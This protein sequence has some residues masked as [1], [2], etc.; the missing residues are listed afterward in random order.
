MDVGK[1]SFKEIDMFNFKPAILVLAGGIT[2]VAAGTASAAAAD[3]PS[4]VVS[5]HVNDLL[6]EDGVHAVYAQIRRAAEA[7]CPDLVTGSRFPSRGVTECRQ[8]AIAG[9]IE[10]I[11]STRLAAMA[12]NQKFG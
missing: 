6:T 3:V 7:V 4:I 1:Y 2:A 10:K 11:P 8:K 12:S 5:Y 9:A